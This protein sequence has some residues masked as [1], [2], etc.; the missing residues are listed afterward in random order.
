MLDGERRTRASRD[1]VVGGHISEMILR[2]QGL[3]EE[4]RSECRAQL[5]DGTQMYEDY[6]ELGI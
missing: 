2:G 5:T 4:D 3:C 6:H 1:P